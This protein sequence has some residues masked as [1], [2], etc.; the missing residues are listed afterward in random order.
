MALK[1]IV[2]WVLRI[3]AAILLLQTLFFKFTGAE[4]SVYIFSQLG[5][6]PK[7]RIASGCMELIAAIFLLISSTVVPGALLTIGIMTGAIASHIFKLG[8]VVQND[9]GL[10]FVYGCIILLNAVILLILH[11]QQFVQFK[12]KL[13]LKKVL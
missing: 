9:G 10:L 4:E 1:K 11:K 5:V 12:Q 13:K 6:E 3:V 8:I 2:S 7:G